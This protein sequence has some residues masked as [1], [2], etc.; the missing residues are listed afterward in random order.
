MG[1]GEAGIVAEPVRR[2][3]EQ[4]RRNLERLLDLAGVDQLLEPAADLLARCEEIV[5]APPAGR[6]M[7]DPYG[8]VPR[9]VAAS[10]CGRLVEGPET[11]CATP[12]PR[13]LR[14]P[15]MRPP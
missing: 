12:Q 8:I 14:T 3:S 15:T 9:A 1:R 6:E 7:H 2:S 10:V 11:V 4:A 13:H 5:V